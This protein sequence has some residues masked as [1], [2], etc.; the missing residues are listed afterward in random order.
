MAVSSDADVYAVFRFPAT[1]AAAYDSLSYALEFYDGDIKTVI[2]VG[3]GS[4][5]ATW[6]SYMKLSPSGI[7]CL[8]REPSMRKTGEKLLDAAPSLKEIVTYENFDLLKDDISGKADLVMSSYVLNEL[9][10]DAAVK[11]AVKMWE[12][13]GPLA[14]CRSTAGHACGLCRYKKDKRRDIKARRQ[15]RRALPARR[16]VQD[17]C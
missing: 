16:R 10:I 9:E 2:D 15:Y 13:R 4:G 12:A 17:R 11:S 6:A 7:R 5:A 3:A 14:F 8:E 1:F